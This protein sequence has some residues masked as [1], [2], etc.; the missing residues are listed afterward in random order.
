MCVCASALITGT[1]LIVLLFVRCCGIGRDAHGRNWPQIAFAVRAILFNQQPRKFPARRLGDGVSDC[2]TI[3][4]PVES[5]APAISAAAF[6]LFCAAFSVCVQ[7]NAGGNF[8]C[9]TEMKHFNRSAA[10]RCDAGWWGVLVSL[11]R[12]VPHRT[13]CIG[14]HT[15][16]NRQKHAYPHT[17]TLRQISL[18]RR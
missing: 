6:G 12:C 18:P 10:V 13:F 2:L 15:L 3:V 5:P 17:H 14:T 9:L 8:I 11:I 4:R 1:T 16:A 7:S